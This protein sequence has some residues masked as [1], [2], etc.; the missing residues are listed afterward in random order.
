MWNSLT[1]LPLDEEELAAAIPTALSNLESGGLSADEA[2]LKMESTFED[3]IEETGATP[4]LPI[5]IRPILSGAS[6]AGRLSR[7]AQSAYV[8]LIRKLEEDT[9]QQGARR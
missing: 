6:W 8:A 5:E 4:A 1:L 3:W 7:P 2:R 9:P